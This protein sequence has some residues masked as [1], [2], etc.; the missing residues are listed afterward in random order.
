M[1]KIVGVG[2]ILFSSIVLGAC[3]N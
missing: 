2:L 1:K 3:G